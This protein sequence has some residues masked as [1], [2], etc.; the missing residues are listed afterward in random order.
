MQ[1]IN[2]TSPIVFE[3]LK[4]K[5]PAFLHLTW[6]P[7]F[8]QTCSF[9]W[10]I[11]VIMVHDLNPEHLHIKGIFL[12]NLKTP[13]SWVIFGHYPQ[14][15]IFPRKSGS[16]IFYPEGTLTSWE[17]SEKSDEPFWR[18]RVYLL[19]YWHSDTLVYW[20]WWNHRTPFCLKTG[21]QK[22]YQY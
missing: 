19:T 10:I 20:Q 16:I 6:E 22:L 9:N 17:V 8:S 15:K 2:F 5:N 7:D 21:V 3:I 4:F 11:K 1:K 18:K 13:Y 12:E 14:N